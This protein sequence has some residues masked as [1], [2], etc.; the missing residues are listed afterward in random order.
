ME[1]GFTTIRR[2]SLYEE[3]AE[4][5]REA[6]ISR[7]YRPGEPLPSELELARQFGVSRNVIREAIR[8]LQSM[9]FLEIRRGPKGGSFV[10]RMDQSA[11]ARNL[12]RL[13]SV[14]YVTINDLAQARMYLEPEVM[15]LAALNATPSDLEE[16]E[17]ILKDSEDARRRKDDDKRITL[18]T[19][20]HRS[21]GRACG[22]PFFAILIDTIMDFTERFVKTRSINPYRSDVHKPGEHRE[23]LEAIK[24]GDAEKTFRLAKKHIG[25]LAEAMKTWEKTYLDKVTRDPS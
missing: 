24:G 19:L 16:I 2:T 10:S 23:I 7:R 11:V 22:N 25:R 14:G 18:N 6:I 9:G 21:V 3:V 12:S 1:S 8:S 13:I 5:L 20:F 17:K 15:R 4:I